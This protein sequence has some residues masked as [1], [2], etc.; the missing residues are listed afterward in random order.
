MGTFYE[1]NQMSLGATDL[2]EV[3]SGNLRKSS[4]TISVKLEAEEDKYM[5]LHGY[6][7]AIDV[8]SENVV[9]YLDNV[10]NPDSRDTKVSE[11]TFNALK[12]R[13]YLTGKTEEE[14]IA[15]VRKLANL[16]HQKNKILHK[17]FLFL[18]AY[19]CN[20]RCSY[21]YEKN[22]LKNSRQ[23]S[24]KVFTKDMVDKA[25][26][27]I[28]S[29][30]NDKRLYSQWITL[31]GGEP[32]LGANKEIVEYIVNK[33]IESGYKFMAVTNGYDL[34]KFIH[35]LSPNKINTLQITIDGTKEHHDKRRMHFQTGQSF[36][37]I[38]ANIGLAIKKEINIKIRVNTDATNFDDIE[39]LEQIF[40]KLGYFNYPKL[41]IYSAPIFNH[42]Q[43][44]K[45]NIH[46]M[47]QTEFE[48]RHKNIDLK[49]QCGVTYL[50]QN[51]YKA[52]IDK[53]L[54]DFSSVYCSAQ[55]GM[56]I[57]DPFGEIYSCWEDVGNRNMVIGNYINDTIQWTN[58]LDLWHNQNVAN[59]E[60]C[61]NCEYVFFCKGGCIARRVVQDGKFGAGFC[62]SFSHT[63]E[64]AVNLV[65]QKLYK[66]KITS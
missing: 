1:N 64:Y 29:I 42:Y 24:K 14:E 21:C 7:G 49:Y 10:N 66:N 47:S 18:V 45:S 62:N 34:D 65:Y 5:L 59:S 6:T 35:L 58:M 52:V 22:V 41:S 44:Q 61:I 19:D 51:L 48:Q 4:Y 15:H 33:G 16:L 20:F 3:V 27:T 25:Y 53:K 12:A 36:D 11:S 8:V 43:T 30:V 55:Y 46:F 2:S 23:W 50:A 37:Q 57:L 31:Y 39:L 26:R 56:Y 40:N 38:V 60:K 63:F 17:N 13:G 28:T 54:V 32:L 9:K